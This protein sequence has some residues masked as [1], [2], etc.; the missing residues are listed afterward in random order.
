VLEFLIELVIEVCFQG[1][2]EAL[3][4]GIARALGAS[5]GRRDRHHPV[6]AA[7]GLLI[8]GAALGGI[9]VL[10]WPYRVVASGPLPGLSLILSP[11]I[12]GLLADAIGS[13]RDHHDRPRTYLSTFWGGALFAFGMAGIRFWL[14]AE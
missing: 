1:G 2:A 7:I 4:E 5:F 11:V 13:W 9:S 10:V 3:I 14:V 6:A 8:L 12:N